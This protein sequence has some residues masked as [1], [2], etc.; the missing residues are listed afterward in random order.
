MGFFDKNNRGGSPTVDLPA[1][2]AKLSTAVNSAKTSIDSA[3]SE[4]FA[5]MQELNNQK[6]DLEAKCKEHEADLEA[7]DGQLKKAKE[8]VPARKLLTEWASPLATLFNL[9]YGTEEQIS[10]KDLERIADDLCE[11]AENADIC[12]IYH[13][14]GSKYDKKKDGEKVEFMGSGDAYICSTMGFEIGNEIIKERIK[15]MLKPNEGAGA[16]KQ[17]PQGSSGANMGANGQQPGYSMGDRG[18]S[19]QKP[20]PQGPS[21]ANM[22][23]NGQQPGYSMGDRGAS[24][25]KPGPQGSSGANMGANGQP[26]QKMSGDPRQ[27]AAGQQQSNLPPKRVELIHRKDFYF[28]D[29]DFQPVSYCVF[30]ETAR[31]KLIELLQRSGLPFDIAADAVG[32][33]INRPIT[34]GAGV[35]LKKISFT[36]WAIKESQFYIV[37]VLRSPYGNGNDQ[38]TVFLGNY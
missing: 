20:G 4:F 15:P 22:G 36:L 2:M 10:R 11:L 17:A 25:Q 32:D 19:A 30:S 28:V 18:A 13:K 6:N 21:G 8:S 16:Q 23:A 9:A 12:T 5:K 14:P 38:K 7:M 29:D 24:A 37:Y 3:L 31:P 33:M 26:S 1:D 34:L 27:G 35:R